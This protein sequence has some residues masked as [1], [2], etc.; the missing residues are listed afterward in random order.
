[1]HTICPH[2]VAEH[3]VGEDLGEARRGGVLTGLLR[4]S[5]QGQGVPSA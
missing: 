4:A 5:W 2:L 3:G 1:V